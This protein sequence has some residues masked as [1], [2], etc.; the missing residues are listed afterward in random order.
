[1]GASEVVVVVNWLQI[2]LYCTRWAT[3]RAD[4]TRQDEQK[5][6]DRDAG[7]QVWG[8]EQGARKQGAWSMDPS[9]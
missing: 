5:L 1:M 4:K 9:P 6:H 2:T 7:M 8:K 3:S